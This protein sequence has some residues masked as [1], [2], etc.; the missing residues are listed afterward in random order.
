MLE[1]LNRIKF[2]YCKL[3][4]WHPVNGQNW[5]APLKMTRN[6]FILRC[7]NESHEFWNWNEFEEY[8]PSYEEMLHE[9]EFK[10]G[11]IFLKNESSIKLI[12]P[13]R[14]VAKRN[15]K[16]GKQTYVFQFHLPLGNNIGRE[17]VRK[18]AEMAYQEISK[19]MH[20]QKTLKKF[21]LKYSSL[22]KYSSFKP[23]R[24]ILDEKIRTV[25]KQL[26][27]EK[28]SLKEILNEN[29]LSVSTFWRRTG[30]KKNFADTEEQSVVI[31]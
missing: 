27:T 11:N 23:R 10:Y 14:R 25:R 2:E 31:F 22:V 4:N 19:G 29:H 3:M 6:E 17:V 15:T 16:S 12:E 8:L 5:G 24:L 28:K 13:I 1:Q 26:Q 7:R 20:I 18:K 9:I 21:H 30:G